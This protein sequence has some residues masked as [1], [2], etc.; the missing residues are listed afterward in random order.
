MLVELYPDFP[1]I[2]E[3]HSNTMIVS[4]IT[5]IIELNGN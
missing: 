2:I 5:R 1:E 3:M 4:F